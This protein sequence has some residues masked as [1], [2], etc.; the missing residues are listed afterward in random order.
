MNEFVDIRFFSVA[1]AREIVA[2]SSEAFWRGDI[3]ESSITRPKKNY[4][5]L[6]VLTKLTNKRY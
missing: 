2:A 6:L 4:L 5:V 1:F 3:A